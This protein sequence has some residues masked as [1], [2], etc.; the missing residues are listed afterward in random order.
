[1]TYERI[2]LEQKN[3]IAVLKFNHP[4]VLNA[5]GAQMLSELTDAVSQ[6]AAPDSGVRCVLLT[7]E[8]RGFS[9]GANLSDSGRKPDAKKKGGTGSSLRTGYHPLLFTLRDLNVPIVT[10]VNGVAAGVGM[11]FA[12]IGDI[13]CAA[14]TA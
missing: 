11:S 3:G 14:K 7:G 13:V 9:A 4:E 6:I 8:G 2:S 10:A 5:I 12:L 1:M